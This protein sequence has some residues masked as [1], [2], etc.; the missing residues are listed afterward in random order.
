M[1]LCGLVAADALKIEFVNKIFR[2]D[3]E[4]SQI[5]NG[6]QHA[7][8][9]GIGPDLVIADAEE[10][11]ALQPRRAHLASWWRQPLQQRVVHAL[12]IRA[13]IDGQALIA[14]PYDV[15]AVDDEFGAPGVD[16]FHDLA[17]HPFAALEPEH[18]AVH[19]GK[20][21]HVLDGSLS[22]PAL[23][24]LQRHDLALGHER[25]DDLNELLGGRIEDHLHIPFDHLFRDPL[26]H[27]EPEHFDEQ[28]DKVRVTLLFRKVTSSAACRRPPQTKSRLPPR[29][30]APARSSRRAVRAALAAPRVRRA[31]GAGSG[32]RR[33]RI[34]WLSPLGLAYGTLSD[35]GDPS[36]P[37]ILL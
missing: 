19:A 11:P 24:H 3:A 23:V 35:S 33:R 20:Q 18:R 30:S 32:R 4:L 34:A 21:L 22:D 29:P 13:V 5:R 7:L 31:Q 15:A 37:L 28:L 10:P 17:R 1:N 27:N 25:H 16:V 14:P 6:G 8:D 9:F 26:R 2:R 12:P 36:G